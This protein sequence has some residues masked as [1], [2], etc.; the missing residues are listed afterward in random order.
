MSSDIPTL[1]LIL[2]AVFL[3][4]SAFFSGSEAALLSVQR[5]APQ[6]PRN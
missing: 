5:G 6:A 1:S 2:L 3:L 4:L